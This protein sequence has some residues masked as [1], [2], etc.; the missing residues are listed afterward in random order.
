MV[1][2]MRNL[3]MTYKQ[4]GAVIGRSTARVMQIIWKNER[5]IRFSP[6]T[7]PVALWLSRPGELHD[8]RRSM[9]A[10]KMIDQLASQR[11]WLVL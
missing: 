6:D 7:A 1:V 10:M 5:M 9:R 4:I 8:L 11:D 2:R 3:S